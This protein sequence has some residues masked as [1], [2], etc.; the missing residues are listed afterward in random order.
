MKAG[1]Y[2]QL[3]LILGPRPNKYRA[4]IDLLITHKFR[5]KPTQCIFHI[6]IHIWIYILDINLLCDDREILNGGMW[7]WCDQ[8]TT[9]KKINIHIQIYFYIRIHIYIF[10]IRIIN[11]GSCFN[12]LCWSGLLTPCGGLPRIPLYINW[13]EQHKTQSFRSIG[14]FLVECICILIYAYMLTKWQYNQV[15]KTSI[16]S[17]KQNNNKNNKKKQ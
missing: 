15:Q 14:V 17:T 13:P 6:R 5:A 3:S 10:Y 7:S 1:Y 12:A 4:M 2:T 9:F 8:R 11:I 16:Y